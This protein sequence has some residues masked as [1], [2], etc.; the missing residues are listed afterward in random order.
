MNIADLDT[1]AVIID[2]DVMERNLARA[3]AYCQQ[4]QLRLRPHTKTH[5]IPAIAQQQLAHGASGIT[6]AKLGEAEVMRAAGI[7]DMLIAYPIVGESKLRRLAALVPQAHITVALDSEEAARGISKAA[8]ESGGTISVLVEVD[9]GLGRCGLAIGPAVSDLC[10]QV[11]DLP[12]LCL[13]GIMTYQGHIMG[14]A[15][16]REKL[17]GEENSRLAIL[18]AL[19]DKAHLSCQIISG[20]S[21]PNFFLSHQI[22]GINEIRPGTYVFND[23]NTVMAQAAQREDCAMSVLATVVSTAVPKQMVV[24]AGSKSLSTDRLATGQSGF[25]Q[26]QGAPELVVT[27][28]SEE[29]GQIDVSRSQRKFSVGDRVRIIPNHVCTAMNLHDEA[30]GVRGDTVECLWPIAG[31]G[32]VR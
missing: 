1:P 4:H 3:A 14:D 9:T 26:V 13:A 6:V 7:T 19:L 29:H 16:A 18:L 15:H 30:Y 23:L 21:T 2:L 27:G 25:G 11:Q 17:T 31:R 28:L 10:H 24:D 20:G 32:K 12:G 8:Q 22:L 5:K